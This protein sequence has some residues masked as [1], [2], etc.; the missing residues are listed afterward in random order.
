MAKIFLALGP[1]VFRDFELPPE[2]S[3]GGKQRIAI[4][5]LA[6]GRRVIDCLGRDDADIRFAGVLTGPE[7][8]WRAQSLDA[9]RASGITVPLTWDV[10]FYSVMVTGLSTVYRNDT[11]I[12]YSI[13][14]SV[15]RDEA[16]SVLQP[17]T[18]VAQLLTE[19]LNA[20]AGSPASGILSF[21]AAT[22]AVQATGATA[23]G[24]ADHRTAL[25]SLESVN[26]ALN[27]NIQQAEQ[28]LSDVDLGA[29]AGDTALAA[30]ASGTT[31]AQQ[32]AGLT[33]ARGFVG[34]ALVN[35]T[36]QDGAS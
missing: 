7:A 24:S 17:P 20:A 10:F 16:D 4:H 31:A 23:Y 11:W 22:A 30:L 27:T 19:D 26:S 18:S 34:R 12:P 9:L 35:L 15:L 3:F 33:R 6:G 1:I 36:D 5:R 8:T 28:Q 14:C 21:A 32:L 25:R 2:I 29:D 13:R